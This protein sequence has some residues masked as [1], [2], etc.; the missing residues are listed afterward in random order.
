MEDKVL[1]FGYG[2]NRDTR[3]M[4]AITG[5]DKLEGKPG[6]LK[7][8]KLCIQR[9]D[10]VPDDIS[11][12]APVPISPRKILENNW[13]S[14]FTSYIIKEDPQSEVHGTIW[15]LTEEER[16]LVADWELVEFGW[17]KYIEAKAIDHNGQAVSVRTEGL[18]EGQQVD[19]EVDGMNYETWLNPPEDFVRVATRSC[20]DYYERKRNSEGVANPTSKEFI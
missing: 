10:Q 6:V 20:K 15:E 13:P 14:D 12:T 3:M 2:A 9:L 19:A 16:A 18:R 5:N 11:P 17:Y 1:Y 7:E 8:F 4:A